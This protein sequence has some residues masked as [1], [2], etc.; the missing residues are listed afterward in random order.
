MISVF[1]GNGS[2]QAMNRA[3]KILDRQISVTALKREWKLHQ[4]A[5]PPS[6]RKRD[7][8]RRRKR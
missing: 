2:N 5:V 3:L 4:F 6:Q 7:K 1:V 8:R